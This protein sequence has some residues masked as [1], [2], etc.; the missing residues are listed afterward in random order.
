MHAPLYDITPWGGGA[1]GSNP[2]RTYFR[3]ARA[4]GP[5]LL[6]LTAQGAGQRRPS[7]CGRSTLAGRPSRYHGGMPSL[8]APRGSCLGTEAPLTPPPPG[9]L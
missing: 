1:R 2:E 7:A 4:H 8:K 9:P 5:S 6:Y 3:A